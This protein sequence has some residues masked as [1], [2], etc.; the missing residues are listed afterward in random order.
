MRL[1]RK[2][3]SILE[4]TLLLGAIIAALVFVLFTGIDGKSSLQGKV[5]SAYDTTGDG[6]TNTAS[7]LSGSGV[8]GGTGGTGGGGK[9]GGGIE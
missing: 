2:A 4:Y 5:K 8:F 7:D 6:I 9:G 1:N 3:Q